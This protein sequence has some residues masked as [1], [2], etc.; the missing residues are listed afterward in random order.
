MIDFIVSRFP[1]AVFDHRWH[2]AAAVGLL[3]LGALCGFALTT[4]DQER[5]LSF[6]PEQMAQGRT[7][8]SST[9][10][11]RDVLY[12]P[13]DR[14]D[15]M[16][17]FASF[18][19]THNAKIGILCFALGFVAGVPVVIL[20]FSNGLILGAMAALYHSRGLGGQ[21][22]AWVMGHGVTE[23]LAVAVCGGAG[24]ALA[25]AL[26]FPGQWTRTAGLA[27]AGRAVAPAIIGAIVMFFVAG[28]LEGYV[29]QLVT[30][31]TVRWLLAGGTLIFYGW[32]FFGHGRR[33]QSPT[34]T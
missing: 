23:L 18:L 8:D 28:L 34:T 27:R 30:S 12:A 32:Y 29:R 9:E 17:L 2:V 4:A 25:R 13:P 20:L 21:F 7:P 15:G 1:R 19:F 11:L 31:V 24:L 3:A 10:A 6:V 16:A 5:Y 26:L 22:L 33:V 14:A